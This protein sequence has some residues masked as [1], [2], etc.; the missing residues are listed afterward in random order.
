MMLGSLQRTVGTL[1]AIVDLE[2]SDGSERECACILDITVAALRSQ[3]NASELS[4]R[5]PDTSQELCTTTLQGMDT[6]K[7]AMFKPSEPREERGESPRT[8]AMES[9]APIPC[10][11][12][13]YPRNPL[14]P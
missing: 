7:P 8:H 12:K 5:M 10:L 14:T 3:S 1:R 11:H 6:T 4:S 13:T 9:P 2:R